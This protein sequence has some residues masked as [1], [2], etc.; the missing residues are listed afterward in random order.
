MA[1]ARY[2]SNLLCL[3][4]L[5]CDTRTLTGT[6]HRHRDLRLRP[7]VRSPPLFVRRPYRPQVSEHG[8]VPVQVVAARAAQLNSVSPS[9]HAT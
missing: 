6:D 9:C 3:D 1:H 7:Q 5:G 4:V 2:G 8:P